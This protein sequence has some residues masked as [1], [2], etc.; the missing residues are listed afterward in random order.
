[1]RLPRQILLTSLLLAAGQTASAE[2]VTAHCDI[3][4]S[5]GTYTYNAVASALWGE[6]TLNPNCEP[7]HPCDFV[8]DHLTAQVEIENTQVGSIF[9][10]FSG[11]IENPYN[12][13]ATYPAQLEYQVNFDLPLPTFAACAYGTLTVTGGNFYGADNQ[14]FGATQSVCWQK[15]LCYLGIS[16]ANG[17][18]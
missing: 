16:V 4:N 17:S 8:R 3:I 11:E 15:T 5:F 18:L 14:A 6:G 1:M 13:P 10:R 2:R 7:E 12:L 9:R